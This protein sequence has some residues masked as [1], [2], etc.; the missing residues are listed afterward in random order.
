MSNLYNEFF[1]DARDNLK[2]LNN[3]LNGFFGSKILLTGAAGFLGSHFCHFFSCL[4]N[5]LNAENKIKV[6]ALDNFIRGKPLWI[7]PFLKRDDFD[8]INTNIINTKSFPIVDYVIHAASVASPVFY[9]QKPIETMDANVVGLRNLLDHIKSNHCKSFLYFSTSE[10]YGDP[11]ELN[12]PTKEDY[13]GYVSSTGPRAS[14]DESKRYG[15]TLCVNFFKQYNVPVKIVRPFNNYGPG[16]SLND[17]RVVSDFFQNV[18]KKQNI[19]LFSDGKATRTFCY[20]AD[21]INAYLLVLLSEYNGHVFNVGNP[22]PE[23]SVEDLAKKIIEIT[24]SNL[25]IHKTTS[26]DVEYLTDNPKRRCP[27]ISKISKMLDFKPLIS[28]ET[29]LLKS[30]R[31]YLESYK[32]SL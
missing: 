29:G 12:I 9:R 16:M 19:E 26:S 25:T 20:V 18:L 22:Q 23:I 1:I 6:Y 10:I 21:A 31:F 3:K 27:D 4:N 17:G 8:I 15:E 28:L 24:N 2:R 11:D 14:Y 7:N 32:G 13:R 30:Y 5:E